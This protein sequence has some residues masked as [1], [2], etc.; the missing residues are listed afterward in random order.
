MTLRFSRPQLDGL[1]KRLRDEKIE[2]IDALRMDL[3]KLDSELDAIDVF[4]SLVDTIGPMEFANL[5]DI[6]TFKGEITSAIHEVLTDESPLHRA[7]ILVRIQDRG[8][9]VG[10]LVPVDNMSSYLSMDRRFRAAGKGY[11]T[12]DAS[13]TGE[14]HEEDVQTN[15]FTDNAQDE[16]GAA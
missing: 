4:E 12:L 1:L 9:H 7:E 5:A 6:D 10:G 8:I 3:A 11:W 13:A 2:Q 16:G 14:A 15:E